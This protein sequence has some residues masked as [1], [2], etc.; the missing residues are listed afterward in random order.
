MAVDGVDAMTKV[1][2][3]FKHSW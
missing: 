1:G 3:T 2:A